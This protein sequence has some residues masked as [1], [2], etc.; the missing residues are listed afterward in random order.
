M[1]SANKSTVVNPMISNLIVQLEGIQSGK[2]WIG[3]NYEKKLD[4][5]GKDDFFEKQGN[6]HSIAE[7]LSHLTAWRSDAILKINTGKGSL[8]DE[9]PSNWRSNE[10]LQK[11]GWKNILTTYRSIHSVFIDLLKDKPDAFLDELYFDVDYK[12]YYPYSFAL[13]GMLH[14]D[15]YHLGQIAMLIKL[16]EKKRGSNA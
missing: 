15:I 10:E 16:M 11:F 8:M 13:Y 6:L 12:G 1:T 3:V 14:H 7:I 9:D 5:L 2:I 4:G